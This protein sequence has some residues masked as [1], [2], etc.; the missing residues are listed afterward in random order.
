[1]A[2]SGIIGNADINKEFSELPIL[3]VTLSE[4]IT[5]RCVGAQKTMSATHMISLINNIGYIKLDFDF[6]NDE[7]REQS[8][9]NL[10]KKGVKFYAKITSGGLNSEL[11]GLL[12]IWKC[13][14]LDHSSMETAKLVLNR[15]RHVANH[16]SQIYEELIEKFGS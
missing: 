3:N 9:K 13:G 16:N 11:D 1:M 4:A 2:D 15:F 10:V 5:L 14:I 8:S 12:S 6:S 7:E